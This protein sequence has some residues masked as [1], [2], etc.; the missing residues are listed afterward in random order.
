MAGVDVI[1]GINLIGSVCKP[2][3]TRRPTNASLSRS[4]RRDKRMREN[5]NA[6][7]QTQ[8]Q[9]SM[10]PCDAFWTIHSYMTSGLFAE[11]SWR[12]SEDSEFKDL[13]WTFHADALACMASLMGEGRKDWV[14]E[15]KAD[16]AKKPT[17]LNILQFIHD[18]HVTDVPHLPPVGVLP[19]L[20]QHLDSIVGVVGLLLGQAFKQG[21][22]GAYEA[23]REK[24]SFRYIAEQSSLYPEFIELLRVYITG[25]SKALTLPNIQSDDFLHWHIQDLHQANVVR[26]ICASVAPS[27]T[28]RGP[29]LSSLVSINPNHS[30]WNGIM[31]TLKS[32]T[33][34]N[35]IINETV[36]ILEECLQVARGGRNAINQPSTTFNPQ[37]GSPE[38][39]CRSRL[40]ILTRNPRNRSPDVERF[41]LGP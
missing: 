5:G 18:E 4:R 2:K 30:G 14:V 8:T 23:F 39:Q 26:C 32:P 12:N 17:F 10:C 19:D 15:W 3:R 28:E 22:P 21:I 29:I 1:L 33:H 13:C 34:E 7:T 36:E 16:R 27:G 35:S 40:I 31:E 20:H 41:E 6:P 38:T 25:V 24:G 11:R 9:N 37:N